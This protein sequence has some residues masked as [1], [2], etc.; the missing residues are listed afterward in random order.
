MFV[1]TQIARKG[2]QFVVIFRKT[3]T[4]AVLQT[5]LRSDFSSLPLFKGLHYY[6][7]GKFTF[8][9]RGRSSRQIGG[10]F[11]KAWFAETQVNYLGS[12]KMIC[13]DKSFFRDFEGAALCG[14]LFEGTPYYA[15]R[16][17]PLRPQVCGKSS[18]LFEKRGFQTRLNYLNNHAK[19]Q[20]PRFLLFHSIWQRFALREEGEFA[21]LQ[22]MCAPKRAQRAEKPLPSRR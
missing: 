22:N 15:R 20:K 13:A 2:T 8:P 14:A 3:P 7:C 11:R 5:A 10:L 6:E 12:R 21:P 4:F 18:A 1:F 17:H 9:A 19:K 16:I